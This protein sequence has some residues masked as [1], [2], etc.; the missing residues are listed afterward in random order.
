ME[1]HFKEGYQGI[2]LH[3]DGSMVRSQLYSPSQENKFSTDIE[4]G[5]LENL[6]NS[7]KSKIIAS[8]WLD[9]P[10]NRIQINAINSEFYDEILK[11]LREERK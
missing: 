4:K 7:Q 6:A 5:E 11:K 3:L 10:V 2:V 8:K 9:S 1:D